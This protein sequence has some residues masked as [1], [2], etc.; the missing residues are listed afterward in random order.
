VFLRNNGVQ[1]DVDSSFHGISYCFR[2]SGNEKSL[3]PIMTLG[4]LLIDTP[5]YFRDYFKVIRRVMEQGYDVIVN[6]VNLQIT[7][8][9]VVNVM[10]VLHYTLP[11]TKDDVRRILGGFQSLFYEG[12][13]EPAINASS[14]LTDRF[15]MDLR[16]SRIDYVH[17][18]PPI[19]S[20]VSKSEAQV[21]GEMGARANEKLIVD[22]RKNPPI[23]L[24]ERLGREYVGLKFLV[25]SSDRVGEHVKSMSF[26]PNMVD[27]VAA[28]DLFVTS[29]GFSSLS[30][31]AVMGT[32]MLI[33]PPEFHFEGLKNL[34]IAE[35]E[36]Y[37]NRI[38]AL[39]E[40][41]LREVD[42]GK[43]VRV[44]ENGLPYIM[45]MLRRLSYQTPLLQN[46][47]RSR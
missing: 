26:I 1:I 43:R 27:Y 17:T 42:R 16:R 44:L 14:I 20:R 46:L 4:R 13:I 36:G 2:K 35:R 40:D 23:R 28:A 34:A 10:N 39:S 18:F 41:I 12:L 33:D 15:C 9:P 7:R 19:V 21:R 8:I 22:G 47:I 45:E 5:H 30:E 32:P 38:G 6:D 24:Y 31:G 37:G 29:S 25:R 3:D 11:Q